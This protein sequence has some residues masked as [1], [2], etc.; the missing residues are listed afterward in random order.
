MTDPACESDHLAKPN[1][2]YE[3]RDC[4][5]TISLGESWEDFRYK[6]IAAILER[7]R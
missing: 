3:I 6:F 2:R 7:P 4:Y 5:A 1:G